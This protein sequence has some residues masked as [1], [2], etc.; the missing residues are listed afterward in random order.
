MVFQDP[1]ACLNPALQVADAI[2]DPLLIHGLCS[3]RQPGRK[4]GACWN[5]SASARSN[6]FKIEY[7][8]SPAA[9]SSGWRSPAPWP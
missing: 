3:K 9:S 4:P 5:G 8:R 6:S 7:Q 2:A 1:L